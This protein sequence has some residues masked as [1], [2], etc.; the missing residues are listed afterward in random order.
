MEPLA[1]ERGY[2]HEDFR[3][4]HLADDHHEEIAYHYHSFHKIIWLLAGR[5]DYA[6]EGKSYHLTPGDCVMVPRGSIHRPEVAEADFYERVILYISPEFLRCMGSEMCDLESCFR[7]ARDEFRYVYHDDDTAIRELLE[8][9]EQ[10]RQSA[11]FG[12]ELLSRSLFVQLMVACNRLVQGGPAVDAAGGDRK[13]LSILQYLGTHLREPLSIDELSQRF[14]MSKYHM[15]RRFREITGYTIHNYVTEKR[16]LLAQQMLG[17]GMTLSETAEY[18]GY[19]DYSTFSR[20]Y[21]KQF[22]VS[23]ST[24]RNGQQ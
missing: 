16:L 10:T 14:Y 8:A 21:K 15:M 24:G 13:M 5:A 7:I 18:C 20:A 12:A 9:L 23:P 22:G 6:V 2:L 1:E 17:R 11:E 3:L 19:Q 4:F